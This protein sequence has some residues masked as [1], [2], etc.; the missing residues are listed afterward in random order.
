MAQQLVG[1][2]T[3]PQLQVKVLLDWVF[4]YLKKV[5]VANLPSAVEILNQGVGDCSEHTTLFTSLSRSLG[6][7]TRINMGLVYLDGR[8]LYHAWPSVLI[9]NHWLTVDPTFG[10]IPADATHL[11]LLEGDFTNLSELLP[12]LGQ[13]RIS[14]KDYE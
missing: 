4:G 11:P 3:D 13:I 7:P 2:V 1:S 6:I 8:F 5:P 10:Q 12:I 14:I 9:D